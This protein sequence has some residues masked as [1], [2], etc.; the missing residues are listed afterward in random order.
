MLFTVRLASRPDARRETPHLPVAHTD[1][2]GDKLNMLFAVRNR[3]ARLL[4]VFRRRISENYAPTLTVPAQL[5][6]AKWLIQLDCK[7]LLPAPT[8]SHE[9][10]VRVGL[11][12]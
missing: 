1:Q 12:T 9:Q 8:I 6:R 10:P 2:R 5:L 11:I 7:A 4:L 3:R